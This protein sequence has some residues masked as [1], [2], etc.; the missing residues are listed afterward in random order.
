MSLDKSFGKAKSLGG[1]R[2]VLNKIERI[3]LLLK[4]NLWKDGDKVIGLPKEKIIKLKKLKT[5]KIDKPEPKTNW[6]EIKK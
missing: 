3:K 4:K 6:E 1:Q 5:E 2:N